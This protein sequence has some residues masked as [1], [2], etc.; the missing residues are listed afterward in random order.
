MTA[1]RLLRVAPF[2]YVAMGAWVYSNQQ[3][4]KDQV[5]KLHYGQIFM[6]SDHT[7]D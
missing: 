2:L 6:N 1:L 5:T 4:F 3:V 7:F